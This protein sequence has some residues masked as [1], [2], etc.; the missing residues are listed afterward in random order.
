MSSMKR[1]DWSHRLLTMSVEPGSVP[2]NDGYIRM[3]WLIA[4]RLDPPSA[5]EVLKLSQAL[6]AAG[7]GGRGQIVARS[8]DRR[9]SRTRSSTAIGAADSAFTLALTSRSFHQF[10]FDPAT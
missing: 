2:I 10:F 3:A 7:P 6:L 5:P 9:S 1:Y 4:R 8:R